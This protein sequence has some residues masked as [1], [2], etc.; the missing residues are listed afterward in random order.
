M[1]GSRVSCYVI[2]GSIRDGMME[3]DNDDRHLT[4]RVQKHY[5]RAH[6]KFECEWPKC[7]KPFG[8][9]L[10]LEIHATEHGDDWIA[11]PVCHMC[12]EVGSH[13]SVSHQLVVS[14]KFIFGTTECVFVG[15][16]LLEIRG[17]TASVRMSSSRVYHGLSQQQW[18]KGI[19]VVVVRNLYLMENNRNITPRT[20]A[21]RQFS[22]TSV[23]KSL[24]L[25]H[26]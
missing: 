17:Q 24:T 10:G 4:G 1:P 22:V 26:R 3:R 21:F 5:F 23:V 15:S 11:C 2:G 18:P 8:T 6:I 16:R 13:F 7:G 12:T 14:R 25:I 19:S 20:L 9:A